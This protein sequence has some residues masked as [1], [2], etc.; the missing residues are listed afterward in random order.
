MNEMAH[1]SASAAC[2]P[3]RG[4]VAVPS[5]AVCVAVPY[6]SQGTSS[7]FQRKTIKPL[8]G[9]G[10]LG[11]WVFGVFVWSRESDSNR[12][13]AHYE[14]AAL[15]LSHPGAAFQAQPWLRD[16]HYISAVFRCQDALHSVMSLMYLLYQTVANTVASTLQANEGAF[17]PSWPVVR[18][19]E[20]SG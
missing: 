6:R 17:V 16:Q 13:P 5:V 1:S 7:N 9:L 19:F 15:P 20:V 4:C 10:W 2:R 3:I 11:C 18:G 8:S 12:R 14:C